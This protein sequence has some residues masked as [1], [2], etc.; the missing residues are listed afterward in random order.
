MKPVRRNH[1]PLLRRRSPSRRLRRPTLTFTPTAWAK[2]LYLRDR[3]PTEIGGFGISSRESL[4]R[5][6][7]IQLPTQQCTETFVTFDD[8]AVA[9]F[10]EEQVAEERVPMEFGR[11]WI[12]TH[13]GDSPQPSPTD[14]RTFAQVFG[15][16][17]WAVMFILARGGQTRA[18]LHWRAGGPALIPVRVEVDFKGIFAGSDPDSWEQEYLSRVHPEPDI[19]P[20]FPAELDLLCSEPS[21][22][23]ADDCD[24]EGIIPL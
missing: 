13:P 20:L 3:G 14:R 6:Q 16:C 8:V 9:E 24:S 11:I 5:V 23:P 15:P 1:S 12:H 10:F 2:L 4:L 7:D 18:E 17:D 22:G 19:S 21:S